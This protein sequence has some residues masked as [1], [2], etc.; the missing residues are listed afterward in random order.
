MNDVSPS[1]LERALDAGRRG[2]KRNGKS[3]SFAEE[4]EPCGEPGLRPRYLSRYF[5]TPPAP[6]LSDCL[7]SRPRPWILVIW[8]PLPT[9]APGPHLS[10]AYCCY[11]RTV[12]FY[13]RPYIIGWPRGWRDREGK[14][15]RDRQAGFIEWAKIE[16]RLTWD[17]VVEFQGE[18][19]QICGGTVVWRRRRW[20]MLRAARRVAKQEQVECVY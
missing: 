18:R 13:H 4:R 6:D 2:P 19:F 15:H 20:W 3:Y 7:V 10:Q 14:F 9:K 12:I 8:E 11:I 17:D 16:T 5:D 1:L